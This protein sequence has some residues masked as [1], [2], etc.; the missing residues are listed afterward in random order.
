MTAPNPELDLAQNTLLD[1]RF[2]QG[3]QADQRFAKARELAFECESRHSY[4]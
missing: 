3:A 2:D 1:L 4:S